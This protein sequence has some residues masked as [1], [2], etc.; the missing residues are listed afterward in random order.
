LDSAK[1]KLEMREDEA[2][3]ALTEW[4]LHTKVLEDERLNLCEELNV[5]RAAREAL[6]A[7]EVS[8]A[9]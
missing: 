7:R 9:L 6:E 5:E 8:R 3:A 2:I 4:E 1:Q